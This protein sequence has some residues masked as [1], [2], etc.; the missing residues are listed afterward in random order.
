MAFVEI[1]G[2]GRAYGVRGL[3]GEECC[4]EVGF[5]GEQEVVVRGFAHGGMVDDHEVEAGGEVG[6]W[7]VGELL[8]GAFVPGD[9][10]VRVQ[11]GEALRGGDH[12]E[13]AARVVPGD[14]F[15]FRHVVCAWPMAWIRMISLLEDV[16][17]MVP[18]NGMRMR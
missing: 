4:G 14:A 15:E 1:G 11:L 17:E 6:E 18:P 10:D 5:E 7:E 9:G 8:Q 13:I 3:I 12:G 2:V 16:N